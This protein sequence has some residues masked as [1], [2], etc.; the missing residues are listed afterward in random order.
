MRKLVKGVL[1]TVAPNEIVLP[2]AIGNKKA[3]DDHGR[4]TRATKIDWLCN[5]VPD[6]DYRAYVQ[7][8]LESALAIIRLLDTAQHVDEFPQFADQYD[9]IML[10]AE[11]CIRHM[12]TLWELRG[13]HRA[14]G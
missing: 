8:E 2:W 6:H 13:S 9:W 5:C 11:V 1:H 12:V 10:R 14:D 3:L 4:P 7:A